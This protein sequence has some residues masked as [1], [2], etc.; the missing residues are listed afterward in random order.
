MIPNPMTP[1][2]SWVYIA[3]LFLSPPLIALIKQAGFTS[4]VNAIIAQLA[5]IVIGIAAAIWSGIPVN[6]ENALP[7]IATATVVGRA[8]YS[9]IW[10]QI[11][12]DGEGNGSVDDSITATTSIVK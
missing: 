12:G 8:A 5:Y 11:G 6:V 4:S 10:S 9:M 3:F 7:L 2:E 1:E